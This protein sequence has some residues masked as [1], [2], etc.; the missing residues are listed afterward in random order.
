ME[1]RLRAARRD[2]IL[3]HGAWHG[4]WCWD[5]LRPL[6]EREGFAVHTP[7]LPGLGDGTRRAG[8]ASHVDAIILAVTDQGLDDAILVGHSYGGFPTAAAAQTL[9]ARVSHLILLDAF[10]PSDGERVIDHAPEIEAEWGARLAADP[11]WMIPPESP[12]SFGLSGDAAEWAGARLRPHP[13]R[14]YFDCVALPGR[15]APLRKTYIRCMAPRS[16]LLDRSVERIRS[17]GSWNYKEIPACHDV[18]IE[19][20]RL[21]ADT[22]KT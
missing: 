14:T 22:L 18:M 21:L 1:A 17:E 11:D 2:I 12:M 8:L 10:V 15:E 9:G 7:T 20:P 6:L 5:L 3:V 13:P 19:N 16:R 4:G